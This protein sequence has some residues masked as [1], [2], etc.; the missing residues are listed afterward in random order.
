MALPLDL[1]TIED[2]IHTMIDD[3]DAS[4]HVAG[5]PV[6][7]DELA[8]RTGFLPVWATVAANAAVDAGLIKD[9]DDF[10]MRFIPERVSNFGIRTDV[11]SARLNHRLGLSPTSLCLFLMEAVHSSVGLNKRDTLATE[12]RVDLSPTLEQ[13]EMGHADSKPAPKPAL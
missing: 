2:V 6:L 10:P 4:W 1:D 7:A 9:I 13:L 11:D 8:D 12:R 5:D 3:M